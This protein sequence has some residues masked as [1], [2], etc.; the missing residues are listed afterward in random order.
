MHRIVQAINEEVDRSLDQAQTIIDLAEDS[1]SITVTI[2]HGFEFKGPNDEITDL[3][4]VQRVIERFDEHGIAYELRDKQ[5]EPAAFVL[6]TA[7]GIDADLICVGGRTRSPVGKVIFGSVAQQI[8]LGSDRPVLVAERS[9]TE[10]D[11]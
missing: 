1:E 7:D 6:K 9:T 3:E 10:A 4:S 5:A 2:T 11:E 8:I